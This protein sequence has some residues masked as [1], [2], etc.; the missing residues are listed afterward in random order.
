MSLLWQIHVTTRDSSPSPIRPGNTTDSCCKNSCCETIHHHRGCHCD[1]LRLLWPTHSP[2]LPPVSKRVDQP[3][4]VLALWSHTGIH[5]RHVSACPTICAPIPIHRVWSRI[6]GTTMGSRTN[7]LVPPSTQQK[8]LRVQPQ[9]LV[10][11]IRTH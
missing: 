5:S 6:M 1:G 7:T 3:P 2:T 9:Q 8:V 10:T 11:G 4:P